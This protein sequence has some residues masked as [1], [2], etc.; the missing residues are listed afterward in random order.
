MRDRLGESKARDLIVKV[1]CRVW[2]NPGDQLHSPFRIALVEV[3][4]DRSCINTCFDQLGCDLEATRRCIWVMK[5]TGIRRNRGLER[6][7]G[8]LGERK[9]RDA[10]ELIDN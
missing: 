8:F 7:C 5:R 3:A 4:A 2:Q 6:I 10:K 9:V 1:E